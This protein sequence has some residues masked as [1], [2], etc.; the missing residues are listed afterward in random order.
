M[1][2]FA[3]GLLLALT[4][5]LIFSAI[6]CGGGTSAPPSTPTSVVA[7]TKNSLV[8]QY[9]MQM[10]QP[11]NA[12][13]EFGT[14]TSYGRQT[15]IVQ[16]SST[17]SGTISVLVAGM[18]ANTT[19]HMR[20][21]ATY[22]AGSTTW[23][24]TDHTFTTG[25]LPSGNQLTLNVTRPNPGNVQQDGVE[26][27]DVTAQ[28]TNNL[29]AAI[30][31]LDGNIIWYN[32]FGPGNPAW[33]F[34][35]KPLPDGNI[36]MN[37]A[38][39]TTDT[40]EEIDLAGNVVRSLSLDSLNA[41][42]KSAGYSLPQIASLH[43]D[44][45]VLP[46]G[47]WVVLGQITQNYTNV[48]GYP[49]TTAVMGDV[50]VDL[51]TNWNPVWVW[52][53]FDHLD[54]NYHPFGLPDWTHSNAVVYSP[55]DGNLFMSMRNQ[56]FVLKI[57]YNNGNG[58]GDVLW[59]MGNKG[60]LQ[61]ANEDGDPTKWFYGQHY[62]F[63]VSQN[64]TQDTIAIFDDGTFRQDSIGDDCQGPYPV[65]FSRA[66]VVDVDEGTK[67]ATV[68]YQFLPGYYT[69]W[70]GSIEVLDNND[71]EFDASQPFGTTVGSRVMEVT[72]DA[73][74]QVVWQ[75]DILGG[76]AYRAY[77]IPSLYAGVVWH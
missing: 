26:L 16:A 38:G 12:W 39:A 48:T 45:A 51:D 37:V 17:A 31:D 69:P 67:V 68:S 57:D 33:A 18:K 73:N 71:V 34:P 64:G 9:T 27:L 5:V 75:M 59:R 44:V 19:Y 49:G 13:V 2:C 6:G 11:V 41:S 58:T 7:A 52:N 56:C 63:L 20:A 50:L 70:G 14:D 23:V 42:I 25:A 47:H 10:S 55:S 29:E 28:G 72:Q 35:I 53:S 40:L 8:A 65:C 4:L 36:L 60:D 61:L 77:R 24:D 22:G 1:K 30:A 62:P 21:H 76:F 54:V 74:A 43:H 3:K 32:D 46:N 15:S 66:I